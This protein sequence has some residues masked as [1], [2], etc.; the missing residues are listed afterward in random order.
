MAAAKDDVA[1]L[2]AKLAQLEQENTKLKTRNAPTLKVSAKGGVSLYGI[3]RFPV[4]LY[5]EQWETVIDMAES[6][7]AFIEENGPE[8]KIRGQ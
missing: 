3:G 5:K 1:A 8:L 7:R 4:T 2:K 6:I